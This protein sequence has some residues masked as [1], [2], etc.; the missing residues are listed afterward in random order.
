MRALVVV[1]GGRAE[2]VEQPDPRAEAGRVVVAVH[3]CGICGSDVHIVEGGIA[4]H[5]QVL[6]HE[7]AGTIVEVG[8]DAGDWRLD[9]AVAVNPLGGCGSCPACREQ[10]PLRCS[11]V[12]NLGLTA[13]GGFA[14]YVAVPHAQLVALPVGVDTELG[15]HAEPLAVALHAVGLAQPAPEGDALVFG[16]GPI[17]LNVIVALRATGAASRIVAVGRSPGRRAAAAALGADVVLDSR[18]TDV[19]E[20]AKEAGTV[21]A[22]VYECSGAPEAVP[23]CAPALAYRGTIVQVAFSPAP[24]PLDT[25]L[26]VGRN[27]RYVGSC[28][29]GAHEYRRAV[30]LVTSGA[31]DFEPLVSE[32]VPLAAA[33]DALQRLRR[34][35]HLVGVLV[36]PWRQPASGQL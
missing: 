32:R 11:E 36:Q 7:F 28:A 20:Y 3:S 33:P 34:P 25:R 15:A 4:R 6:G 13:P 21:F 22:Q 14:E 5:G 30:E 17:G 9:Q 31:V 12:P 1:P 16:V 27:L 23:T 18:E 8:P 24:A 35:E 26:F 29:F 2:V 10:L 19:A